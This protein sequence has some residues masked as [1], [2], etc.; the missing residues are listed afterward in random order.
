MAILTVPSQAVKTT[1]GRKWHFLTPAT[2]LNPNPQQTVCGL[3]YFGGVPAK[4][5]EQV[6]NLKHDRFCQKCIGA[7]SA[8][9]GAPGEDFLVF[10]TT[11]DTIP[12]GETMKVNIQTLDELLDFITTTKSQKVIIEPFGDQWEIEIYNDYRE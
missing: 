1:T 11:P 7:M 9:A 5:K 8:R 12:I 2:S 3:F 10:E 6:K 4:F